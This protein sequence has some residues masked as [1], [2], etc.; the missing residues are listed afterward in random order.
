MMTCVRGCFN[1][2]RRA[3]VRSE[4][5]G[6]NKARSIVGRVISTLL[7]PSLVARS[8]RRV[9]VFLSVS[10]CEM[11]RAKS[12]ERRAT[13]THAYCTRSRQFPASQQK[14]PSK[15]ANKQQQSAALLLASHGCIPP[16]KQQAST[17][18]NCS[19]A[20]AFNEVLKDDRQAKGRPNSR[21]IGSKSKQAA[22]RSPTSLQ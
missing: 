15:A 2:T 11:D 21:S 18:S 4:R 22:A 14:Q 9:V 17:G 6:S 10:R 7:P 8:D 20:L 12:R 13:K 3:S 5:G 19:P 1:A 16:Y